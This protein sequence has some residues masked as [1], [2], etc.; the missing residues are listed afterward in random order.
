MALNW[1]AQKASYTG[2]L[3]VQ[4]LGRV[5]LIAS[6]QQ[7]ITT[8]HT[9]ITYVDCGTRVVTM[10]ETVLGPTAT[11]SQATGGTSMYGLPWE[12]GYAGR[13]ALGAGQ[14][15]FVTPSLNGCGVLIGGTIAAPVVV[16]ANCQPTALISP[17]QGDLSMYYRLWS[18]V[19]VTVASQLVAGGLLPAANLEMLLP[20][21]YM[22]PGVSEASVFG[23]RTSG[24]WSF[25]VTLNK[26]MNGTTRK[27]WG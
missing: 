20:K 3:R 1:A 7:V 24:T 10:N 6:A 2:K 11:M 25:Y 18:D 23:V 13:T 16:H 27:I 4:T 14:D 5:G 19:Y 17:H 9:T 21:D 8:N 15:I 22:L 12:V 26:A